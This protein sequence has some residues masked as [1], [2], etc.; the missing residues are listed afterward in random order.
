MNHDDDVFEIRP[1]RSV[2]W[3]GCFKGTQRALEKLESLGKETSNQCFAMNVGTRE[4][5]GRV[6]LRWDAAQIIANGGTADA[7]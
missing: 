6:N 5:V 1:D 7:M 4:I 3:R 2:T